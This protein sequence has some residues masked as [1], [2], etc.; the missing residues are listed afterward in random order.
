[1]AINRNYSYNP[2][3]YPSSASNSRRNAPLLSSGAS[4][5]FDVGATGAA[6]AC[7]AANAANNPAADQTFM[8]T[9]A[10][11]D[12]AGQPTAIDLLKT[13]V[14]TLI[15]IVESLGTGGGAAGGG[16]TPSI[17]SGDGQFAPANTTNNDF[18]NPGSVTG[19]NGTRTGIT[20]DSANPTQKASLDQSLSKIASDPDGAKLI[21]QA[22]KLGV[23]IKVGDP[24]AAAKGAGAKDQTVVECPFCQQAAQLQAAGDVQGAAKMRAQDSRDGGQSV[25]KDGTVQVNGVTLSDNQTGKVTVVVR[26]PS[27]IKTIAHELVHAVSTEDGNSQQEEGIAD[28]IGSRVANNVG[29]TQHA[30]QGSD[31]QIYINKQ[32]YYPTLNNSNNIRQTL[33]SLGINIDV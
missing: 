22:K 32:Q 21:A 20:N 8:P 19:G 5:A 3:N 18:T 29:D 27:N 15:S 10:A 1:M 26:D 6:G 23:T 33:A 2:A 11:A 12:A 17:A 14:S 4:S 9:N 25:A 24:E 28:V 30:L 31:E 7:G 13:I 16:Q